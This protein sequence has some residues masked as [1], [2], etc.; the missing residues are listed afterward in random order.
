MLVFEAAGVRPGEWA[1]V[2]PAGGGLGNLLVQLA[3]AAGANVVGAAR[4]PRKLTRARDAGADAAV[5][6]ERDDWH[7]Q[8][9]TLTGG[10]GPDVVLDGVGGRIGRTSLEMTARG[11]RFIGYGGPGGAFTRVDDA[12]RRGVHAISLFDLRMATGDDERL[13]GPRRPAAAAGRITPLIG[14]T[15]PLERAAETHA[16]IEARAAAGKT[17]LLT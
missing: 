17:L 13:A 11:G 7:D 2:T 12:G 14:Q 16:M 9:R 1:L 3:H 6:Y 8:I 4:G 10:R 15:L 5:D